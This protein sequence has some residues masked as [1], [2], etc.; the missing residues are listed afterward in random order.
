MRSGF[1]ASPALDG[2]RIF[3][4]MSGPTSP[5]PLVAVDAGIEGELQ[6][7]K[8]FESDKLAWSITGAGPGMASP[9]ISQGLLYI[10]GSN[11][12]LNCYD[13]KT[14]ER[15]YRTRVKGMKTVVASLWA[16]KDRVFILDE[17]G[18]TF[19]VKPGREFE[20]LAKNELDDL[21]W[22][23]PTVADDTLV[24]RGVEKL[25]CIRKAGS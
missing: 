9:V 18:T 25:Y 5:A 21:V 13:T 20:L 17:N 6:L 8:N 2:K 23:T 22:S 1:S 7:T 3:F 14:G 4:G 16:D 19:V 24:V 11:A 10:P 15:V 12:I